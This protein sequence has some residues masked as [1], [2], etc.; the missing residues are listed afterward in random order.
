MIARDRASPHAP[1]ARQRRAPDA[2]GAPRRRRARLAVRPSVRSR[3]YFAVATEERRPV[4]TRE[5]GAPTGP[6]VALVALEPDEPVETVTIDDL[7]IGCTPRPHLQVVHHPAAFGETGEPVTQS[8]GS[9]SAKQG[10]H[11]AFGSEWPLV[12]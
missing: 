3:A 12:P 4:A 10:Q 8:R 1:A 11:H 7:P 9:G 2:R 6:S 5:G